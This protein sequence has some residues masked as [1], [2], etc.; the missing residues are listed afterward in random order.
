M[1][2]DKFI[3]QFPCGVTFKE[4]EDGKIT[5]GKCRQKSIRILTHLTHNTECSANL[6]ISS[7]KI[8][9][10]KF[11]LKQRHR[12]HNERAKEENKDTYKTN[13]RQRQKKCDAKAKEEDQETFKENQRKRQKKCDAKAKG[14][15]QET[16][17]KNQRQRQKKCDEKAKEEDQET[18]KTKHR[19][20]HKKC[21]E[22]AKEKCLRHIS[23]K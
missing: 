5:C 22:K 2:T 19:Q 13:Q 14:E 9:L 3:Y 17:K 10:H 20:R 11:R 12:K 6:N 15:D 8:S 16:F 7:L 18:Y 21:K 4:E 1:T 23:R